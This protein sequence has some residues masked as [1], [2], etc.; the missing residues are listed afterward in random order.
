MGIS[1]PIPE[2]GGCSGHRDARARGG[3]A[4]LGCACGA[5]P[6]ARA[7]ACGARHGA[8]TLTLMKKSKNAAAML[9][10]LVSDEDFSATTPCG[11]SLQLSRA[12]RA[13]PAVQGGAAEAAAA[14]AATPA[15]QPNSAPAVGSL[16]TRSSVGS[17]RVSATCSI[18]SSASGRRPRSQQPGRTVHGSVGGDHAASAGRSSATPANVA[19]GR[20]ARSVQDAWLLR[21]ISRCNRG[22]RSTDQRRDVPFAHVC[23]L[24]T[25][26]CRYRRGAVSVTCWVCY[27]YRY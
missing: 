27:R 17:G 12:S 9:R 23:V 20:G 13:A 3:L 25:R 10:D 21:T 11:S 15:G 7:A 5:P 24:R 8:E 26:L 14:R 18:A 6:G 4:A 2:V 19:L 1:D 22:N 16:S